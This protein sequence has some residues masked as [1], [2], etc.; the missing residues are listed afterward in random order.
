M[1][2]KGT[3]SI[4]VK[5]IVLGLLAMLL[6]T[7]PVSVSA[8]DDDNSLAA[9][10][11]TTE[12]VTVEPEFSYDIWNY[13]VTVPAGTKE[14]TLDPVPSSDRAVIADISGT[15]LA[16]DGTGTV[17]ITVRAANGSE[18]PYQLNVVSSGEAPAAQPQEAETEAPAPPETEAQTEAQKEA[19]TENPNL[20]RVDKNT[21]DEAQ[22]TIDGL[23]GEIV[24]YRD[25]ISLY[26][27]IMYGL[28]AL[29]VILFFAVINLLLRK[30]DLKAE[31][32]EYR[33]LGYSSGK[34]AKK[35][36]KAPAGTGAQQ[37]KP[38]QGGYARQGAPAQGGY[39][40]NGR[41][42]SLADGRGIPAP[43]QE[44]NL[45]QG[46]AAQT[47]GQQPYYQPAQLD[48]QPQTSRKAR[49]LPVYEDEPYGTQGAPS[50][51]AGNAP[52][53]AK[54][55]KAAKKETAQAEKQAQKAAAQ[56]RKEAQ[57]AAAQAEKEAQKA[58]SQAGKDA[59][60][61]AK[62]AGKAV[63]P[64]AGQAAP[65]PDSQAPEGTSDVRIDMIDL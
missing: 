17:V 62:E 3:E 46:S 44:G 51:A 61:A 53:S 1:N 28:I 45:P 52:A 5:T 14:L 27:K 54:E 21:L 19:Q 41:G 50:A 58:A 4:S 55:V 43:A 36:K 11:I 31:L 49:H 60:R 32:K 12:G 7:I 8:S 2:K 9:L 64:G 29:A 22:D 23:K 15:Q 6:V 38:G 35:N 47:R 40:V 20:V 34:K 42:P 39:P 26:T 18:F 33:S 13:T 56:A 57:R 48:V 25:T 65:A 37:A 59:A 24:G 16:D 30:N 63:A 10:G